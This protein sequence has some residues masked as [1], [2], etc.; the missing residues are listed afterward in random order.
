MFANRTRRQPHT[1]TFI[2][3][4]KKMIM[5][6]KKRR[7]ITLVGSYDAEINPL[8]KVEFWAEKKILKPTLP[9][10]KWCKKFVSSLMQDDI[11]HCLCK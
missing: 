1:L 6:P 2:L 11:V 7:I 10:G 8:W 4:N 9:S 5:K 3:P